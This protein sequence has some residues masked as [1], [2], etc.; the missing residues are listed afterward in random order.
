[1]KGRNWIDDEIINFFFKIVLG[2]KF[3]NNI[4]FNTF[5]YLKMTNI[6]NNNVKNWYKNLENFS[7]IFI[8]IHINGFYFILFL[9]FFNIFRKS[10]GYG[11]GRK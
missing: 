7:K 9:F 5:F 1:L 6:N 8:P 4:Y 2:E 10:L 11:Y 3:K